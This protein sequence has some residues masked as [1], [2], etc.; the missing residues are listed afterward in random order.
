MYHAI[1]ILDRPVDDSRYLDYKE[2]WRDKAPDLDSFLPDTAPEMV[3]RKAI[4]SML[5]HTAITWLDAH[6]G[7]SGT[8][9]TVYAVILSPANRSLYLAVSEGKTFPG[10]FQVY[11]IQRG[12]P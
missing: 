12:T 1:L 6:E 2:Y 5:R 8:I 10:Q 9:P 3:S 4:E 11:T 7:E